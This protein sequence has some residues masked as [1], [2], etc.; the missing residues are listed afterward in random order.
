MYNGYIMYVGFEVLA[1]VMNSPI[2]WDKMLCSP[3]KSTDITELCLHLLQAS[4]LP[5]LLFGAEDGSKM[6]LQ[7]VG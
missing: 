1:V 2:F 5:G 6:L 7:N 3:L 4:F